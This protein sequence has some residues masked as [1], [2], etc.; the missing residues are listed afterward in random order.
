[1]DMLPANVLIEV[2]TEVVV[3]GVLRILRRWMVQKTRQEDRTELR[4]WSSWWCS[5]TADGESESRG[6]KRPRFGGYWMFSVYSVDDG[7]EQCNQE[8]AY[9][10]ADH[11]DEWDNCSMQVVRHG[12]NVCRGAS[13]GRGFS[14]M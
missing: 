5:A 12:G 14:D 11:D 10:A 13:R 7:S 9:I 8:S 1:M 6:E 3:E 2:E 4:G